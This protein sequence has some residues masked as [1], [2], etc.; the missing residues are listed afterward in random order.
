MIKSYCVNINIKNDDDNNIMEINKIYFI[1]HILLLY[2]TLF[3]ILFD[4]LFIYII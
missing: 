2:S 4:G 3:I 1:F